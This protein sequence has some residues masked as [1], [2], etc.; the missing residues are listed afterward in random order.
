M[1]E[2][3]C[4]EHRDL[5]EEA[6]EKSLMLVKNDNDILP[7]K[8]GTKVYITGPAADNVVAQCGGAEFTGKLPSPCYSSV[9]QIGTDKAWLEAGWG[10]SL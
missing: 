5:E 3:D 7:L 1:D 4:D 10:L 9:K 6:V 2:P 8:K